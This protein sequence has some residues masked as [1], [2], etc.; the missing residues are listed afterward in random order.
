MNLTKNL[1]IAYGIPPAT[2]LIF[3]AMQVQHRFF[4]AICTG[5]NYH[6][7]GDGANASDCMIMIIAII[8]MLSI[9]GVIIERLNISE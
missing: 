5:G 1:L 4:V 9:S 3:I 8:T 6:Q 7:S 2:V